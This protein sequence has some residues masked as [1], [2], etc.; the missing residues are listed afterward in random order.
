M[1]MPWNIAAS[2][3]RDYPVFLAGGLKPENVVEAVKK[4]RPIAIDLASGLEEAPGRKNF[5]AIDRLFAALA[6]I[7]N[8]SGDAV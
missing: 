3:C 1:T 5:E 2:L 4:V 6:S 8:G 7:E